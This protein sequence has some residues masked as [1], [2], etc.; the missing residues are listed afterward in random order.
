MRAS[1]YPFAMEP[2][3]LDGWSDFA[4]ATAGASAALAGLIIVAISVNIKEIIRGSSLPARAI[5][6][7][8]AVMVILVSATVLLVPGQPALLLGL[9]LVL[10]AACALGFQVNAAVRMLSTAEGASLGNKVA[11]TA[12]GVIPVLA[13]LIGGI[14][15]AAGSPAGLGLLAAGFVAIFV[16]STVNAW[17]LLVE[18]LR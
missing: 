1:R 13:V 2:L 10:F 18:I 15:I 17:V 3:D 5:A 12:L 6:T 9:E 11:S 4:V 8:A 16:V 7:I 14:V